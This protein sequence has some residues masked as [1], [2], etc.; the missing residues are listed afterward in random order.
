MMSLI[1]YT[2]YTIYLG[3]ITGEVQKKVGR[4]RQMTSIPTAVQPELHGDYTLLGIRSL[5]SPVQ[6]N[7]DI[8]AP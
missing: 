6:H 3:Y 8:H 4:V 1:S 5:S 7:Q 2:V